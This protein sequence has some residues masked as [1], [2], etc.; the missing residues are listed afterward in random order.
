VSRQHA[1]L[2]FAPDGTCSITDQGSPN[3][4]LVN[5]AEIPVGKPVPLRDGDHVNLGA[6]TRLTITRG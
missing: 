3:G 5:G 1:S 6:W 4:T 2:T